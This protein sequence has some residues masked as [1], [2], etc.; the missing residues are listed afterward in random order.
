MEAINEHDVE[1]L[2]WIHARLVNKY[3]ED[4]YIEYMVRFREIINKLD[5]IDIEGSEG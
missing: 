2:K 5:G 4:E 1:H 3:R